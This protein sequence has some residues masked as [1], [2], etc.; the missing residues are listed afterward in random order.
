MSEAAYYG[1]ESIKVLKGL[2]AVRKRPGMYIGDTEDGSGLHHM[3]Y[4]VV[5]NAIDESLAG[6]CDRIEVILYGDGSLAVQD[7]GR[8]V[9]TEM[10]RGE[11]VSAAQVIMTHLH[12]G[13]KFDQNS[14]KVSGGLHGVGVSVVNALSEWLE[15]TIWRNGK[16]HMLRFI[17]G[18][19]QGKLEVIRETG[20]RRGTRVHFKPS[21]KT[22]KDPIFDL[23]LLE[24]RLRELSF[25]NSGVRILLRD[26][27]PA[28]AIET[29]LHYKGGLVA[30]VGH[31]NAARKPLHE[32]V[33][34]LNCER[35]QM[36]LE[37]ALQWTD[38]YHE[39]M[40]CFTNNIPQRDGGTHLAGFRA[41]LTRQ[42]NNYAQSSGL[43]R[44]EKLQLTGE[45]AR[46]GLTAILSVKLPDPKFS[47]QTKDKLVSSE[48]RGTVE[49]GV[50]EG[51]ERHLEQNPQ[52]ARAIVS[53]VVEAAHA[54]EAARQAR[55]L[56]RRK[57]VL[58][59]ASLP[60]KLA[61][62]QS[63]LAAESEVFL[64]EGDSAGGS[65][66]QGRDRRIQAVLPLRG[67]I[68]NVERARVD[69]MLS[70]EEI[71][72][73]I[74]ALGAGFGEEEM[75]LSKL[76]YHKVIIMTDADVDGS[77]IRT[78]LLTFFYRNYK[79]L[80]EEG[81]LYIARPPLFRAKRGER[82]RYLRDEAALEQFL[83]NQ[84]AET[85][86]FEVG[87]GELQRLRGEE[88]AEALRLSLRVHH[89]I[90]ALARKVGSVE[91][92][93]QAAIAGA[94]DLEHY[95]DPARADAVARYLAS[96]LNALGERLEAAGSWEGHYESAQLRN[97]GK[98]ERGVE[99]SHGKDSHEDPHSEDSHSEDSHGALVFRR[100]YRGV[101]EERH[102][103]LALVN[104]S[105]GRALNE[106]TPALQEIFNVT[107]LLR[108]LSDKK[109][110]AR[111]N[112]K[113]DE[114]R[115]ARNLREQKIKGPLALVDAVFARGRRGVMI[116]RYKG[117][118][119]MNPQ[120]LWETTMDPS[121][122]T[123]LCVR[124][125]H[126]EEADRLFSSLMG[127]QVE[128]RRDFILTESAHRVANLDI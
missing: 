14:Y 84:G 66:K 47:S 20:E 91:V 76:R 26:E 97:G 93:E 77:H 23:S 109:E 121:V 117:L 70:N 60:G 64:V 81:H 69:K 29:E 63:R 57:G 108:D 85:L 119:E 94:L 123:L 61:D 37:C 78:L 12:A 50:S 114:G 9:P 31:L 88:L 15:M 7:N 39:T 104:S 53:K 8:G 103:D 73:M 118:G 111:K 62:C 101:P 92:L 110:E 11:Q 58:D 32:E 40:L 56:T 105:E 49:Q 21:E 87:G 42:I 126:A 120:Q 107:G 79:R 122:R 99:S 48:V 125:E 43:L 34:F 25:L 96:R 36:H 128:P 112:G 19:P 4:E 55:E 10:H 16:E 27:R 2:E 46:E 71:G 59:I 18:H 44:R 38:S 86:E 115:N 52:I 82:I 22:F 41:A 5:D 89:L 51:L 33:I 74:T 116:S 127:E 98:S 6:Y 65:A 13:G 67:K 106:C 3:V 80:I 124:I 35:D 54:R 24:H 1:A 75:D 28:Q 45:D 90:Q 72:T 102:L 100:S 83:L 30:F 68:L 17:D 113:A 95:K